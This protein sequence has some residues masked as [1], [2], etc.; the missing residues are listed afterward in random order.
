MIIAVAGSGG[1]TTRIHELAEKYRSEGKKVFVTT[2]THMMREADCDVS[3]DKEKIA[4]R[5]RRSGYCMA[6]LPVKD[7]KIGALP[8]TVYEE[9][10]TLA[11]VVLV[12]AD[13]SRGKPVKAPAEYEPVIPSN[14]D[15][16]QIVVGLS[17]MGK[18]LKD[19]SHRTERIEQKFGFSEDKILEAKDLQRIVKEAYV[20]P[21]RE[22]YPEKKICVCPGQ[23]NSL[24]ERVIARFLIEEREIWDLDPAW[25]AGKPK[26]VILG[27]GHVGQEV[28][29]LG[30]FLDFEVTVIDDREEFVSREL[31][32]KADH[33]YCHGFER[34]ADILPKEK[35]CFYVVVTRGHGADQICVAQL[36]K[37][38]FSYLGMIGSKVKVAK[39][40]ELLEEQGFSQE[41]LS[42]I[43][44]PIG[45]KIGAK[46]PAEIAVSIGAEIILEKNQISC[47]S[48][49][50]E[51]L[52]T[53]ENGVLC[54]ITEKTGSAPRDTGTMMLVTKKGILGTIGGGALEQEVILRAGK[55]KRIT[56]K[57]YDLSNQDSAALGMI[58]GGTNRILYV[59]LD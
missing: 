43:H 51:L 8:E 37:R 49:P 32:P 55:I 56:E 44:A 46:T 5:L 2:T 10:C 36:L 39:T 28:A 7:G 19:I 25:F 34:L 33:L 31:F 48:L 41:D 24:Y 9:I 11:D 1:K 12:E 45:L 17:A 3:G 58:C 30:S 23:I 21:L 14:A 22:K 26:L 16:I 20:Q 47:G 53:K 35:N 15:E 38:Q 57:T 18:P 6:G 54:I 4:D 50:S 29:Q 13:G 59:P 27:G 42:K 40:K 52:E